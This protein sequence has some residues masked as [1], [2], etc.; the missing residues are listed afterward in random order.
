VKEPA[1]SI[2]NTRRLALYA[3]GGVAVLVAIGA[4]V[5]LRR[6]R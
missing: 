2:S 6:K 1:G 4:I 5:M 3:V